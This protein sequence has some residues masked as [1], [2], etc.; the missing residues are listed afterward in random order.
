MKY[1]IY[2]VMVEDT[3]ENDMQVANAGESVERIG[4]NYEPEDAYALV[5]KLAQMGND[6]V[7]E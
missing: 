3:E 1:A 6:E 2:A 5:E 7:A 4:G